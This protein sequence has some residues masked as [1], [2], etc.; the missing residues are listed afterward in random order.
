MVEVDSDAAAVVV[1]T[2]AGRWGED[3]E[4]RRASVLRM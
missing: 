4:V 2:D 3:E 1:L